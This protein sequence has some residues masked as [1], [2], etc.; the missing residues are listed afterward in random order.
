SPCSKPGTKP[1]AVFGQAAVGCAADAETAAAGDFFVAAAFLR[2]RYFLRRWRFSALLYCLL[3]VLYFFKQID[4][5]W[6]YEV[7]PEPIQRQSGPG[8]WAGTSGCLPYP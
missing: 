6:H 3:I 2:L 5:L 4:C 7:L 1:A 8:A